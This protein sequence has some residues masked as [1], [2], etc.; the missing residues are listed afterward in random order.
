MRVEAARRAGLSV[1]A[2]TC[3]WVTFAN[4]VHGRYKN[5]SPN[6]N[7]RATTPSCKI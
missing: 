1:T 7:K 5:F 4:L 2:D 3:F 6:N